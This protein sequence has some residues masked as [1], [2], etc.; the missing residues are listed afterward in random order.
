MLQTIHDDLSPASA[1]ASSNSSFVFVPDTQFLLTATF[2]RSGVDLVLTGADNR[3]V[4]IADYFARDEAPDLVGPDGATLTATVV[5]MLAGPAAP[6][7]YAQATPSDAQST[8]PASATAIA[9]VDKA[10]GVAQ[11]THA[12]G[13]TEPLTPGALIFKGD[14]IQTG[15]GSAASI[16]FGD[17]TALNFSANTRMVMNE[18]A[19]E[20]NSTANSGVLTLVHGSF[21]F[22]AGQVAK[23][24]GLNIDTPVATM[25]IRGTTGGVAEVRIYPEVRYQF[26]AHRDVLADGTLDRPS[27]YD[28]N[29]R[30]GPGGTSSVKVT[31][32]SVAVLGARGPGQP[33]Q[34]RIAQVD[35]LDGA[36]ALSARQY[37]QM[38]NALVGDYPGLMQNLF[39]LQPPNQGPGKRGDFDNPGMREVTAYG[40]APGSA[41]SVAVIEATNFANA[42]TKTSFGVE[43]VVPPTVAPSAGVTSGVSPNDG[44]PINGTLENLQTAADNPG[45]PTV[46]VAS[47]GLPVLAAALTDSAHEGTLTF[48]RDLLTGASS[49]NQSPLHIAN[50]AFSVDGGQAS[51]SLPQGLQ[52]NGATLTV[53]PQDPAFR[54]LAGGEQKTIVVS[55]SVV[56]GHGSAVQ[57]TETITIIGVDDAP[58]VSAGAPSAA[59]AETGG[60]DN[61]QAGVDASVVVLAKSDVDS[62]LHYDTTGWLANED[63]T[64]T[65]VGQ[66]GSA[67]LDPLHDTVTYHLDNAMPATQALAGGQHVTDDFTIAVIEDNGALTATTQVAF[68]VTGANDAAQIG[69]TATGS[70]TED[71]IAHIEGALTVTDVDAGEARFQTPDVLSGDHGS[72]TF[73]ATSGAWT[74]TLNQDLAD[75]LNA[76]QIVHDTLLV[77]SLD[78]TASQTIDVAIHGANDVPAIVSAGTV[79]EGLVQLPFTGVA[80]SYLSAGNDLV[81]GLGSAAGYNNGIGDDNSTGP[82][83]ITSV[84]GDA[85][86]NFFGT[87]YKSL[88][89]NNNG[90]ISFTSAVSQF[91]PSEITGEPNNPIINPIIAPFWADVDTRGGDG[92]TPGDD[93]NS[94]GTNRVFYDLDADNHVL[95]VTWDDVGYFNSH[96]GKADA[97]QLQIIGYTD[98]D[99]AIVYRYEDIQWTTGD[100][101]GGSE[102]L[103]GTPARAGFSDGHGNSL[104]LPQSGNQAAILAL[105]DTQGN[106][107]IDGVFVYQSHGGEVIPADLQT[108]GVINFTDPDVGDD[109]T[110]TATYVSDGQPLGTFSLKKTMTRPDQTRSASLAGPIPSTPTPSRRLGR[111]RPGS[112]RSASISPTNTMVTLSRT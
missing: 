11:V 98:G 96:T 104:E 103:G 51:S 32:G 44:H 105:P 7:Q 31:Y 57:Q 101:S 5:R 64:F 80:L 39:P 95:T 65:K 66:Y 3:S 88:Y 33:P 14:I 34:L 26:H 38:V 15:R 74:Y 89:I 72:F 17:G 82:I 97:F 110:A 29:Y 2:K 81:N 41:T 63:G 16:S 76:G 112:R 18:F 37:Q 25:G 43:T 9:R 75:P 83:D 90:S 40:G 87:P 85:G 100:A 54:H 92:T 109:H 68:A 53:D 52:L 22:I 102:G 12:N 79:A 67:T 69:G 73:D 94:T 55:Y 56:D 6:G 4:V 36:D 50:V 27:T 62:V 24:G 106:T 107:G 111:A 20:A 35:A 78:G 19:Y 21:A 70:V 8:P 47:L 1:S 60:V 77:T 108:S 28:L 58:T 13:V 49:G 84:F 59:L 46:Q 61:A 42:A 91:T 10:S 48:A 86:L 71:G 45:V 93:G 30:T 99:F 23:T